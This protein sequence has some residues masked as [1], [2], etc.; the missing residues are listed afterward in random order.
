MNKNNL[1]FLWL[2]LSAV[3]LFFVGGRWN[4][5]LAA[6]L[7]PAVMLRF[8]RGSDRVWRDFLLLW[9]AVAIPNLISWQGATSMHFIHPAAETIFFIL[10]VPLGLVPNVIDRI[11]YRRF[12][13]QFWVTLV[14]PLAATAMDFFSSSG[15][16]FG[17]FGAAAYSQR[18]F[19]PVMQLASLTG[20][21]GI[22]FIIS[23]FASVVNGIGQKGFKQTGL[24]FVC[25]LAAV[26]GFGYGR[27]LLAPQPTHT[28]EIG[29][30]SM[31]NGELSGLMAQLQAGDEAGL[32]K[33]VDELHG[34]EL[35]KVRSLAGQGADIVVLQEGAGFGYAD[36]VEKLLVDM[37]VVAKEQKIYIVLPTFAFGKEKPENIVHIIDPNGRIVLEHVKYGGNQ[38]EGT[39]KGD[40]VLRTV[41]TPYGKLSAIICWDADF[42][43]IVRQAGEQG[44]GLLF[45]PSNDWYEVRDI[46]A[47]MATFRAVENGMSIFRQAG[48]GVSM[49]TDAYGREANRVDTFQAGNSLDFAAVQMV[50]TPIIPVK[51]VYP[52]IGD[53]FGL[54]AL[55]ALSV[56]IFGLWLM[57]KM[58]LNS[59]ASQE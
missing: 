4:F 17:S 7:A 50:N 46:H 18:G 55:V 56:L 48:Q 41:D 13:P 1:R 25:V 29:G 16:P 51:T 21:W 22:T 23:W 8:F 52:V 30:F 9:V 58:P 39:L 24:I 26:F 57:R 40:G 37:A 49:V 20:L 54:L 11:Y 31:P 2:V 38:F 45:I 59:A 36:Q 33:A 44:V 6:W 27:V 43:D 15:S 53:G 42:P 3:L 32:R 47:G 19:L 10:T 12:G 34:Q 14:Y 35:E 28:P 5:P